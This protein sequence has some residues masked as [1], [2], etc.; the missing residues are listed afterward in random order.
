MSA[1]QYYNDSIIK[2]KIK[3][4]QLENDIK[5][6]KYPKKG[7]E[8]DRKN[9]LIDEL[10]KVK[11]ELQNLQKLQ[12]EHDE[13]MKELKKQNKLNRKNKIEEWK[14]LDIASKKKILHDAKLDRKSLQDMFN[15]NVHTERE[16][17]ELHNSNKDIIQKIK[18]N[19]K[20]TK[21]LEK[22]IKKLNK[23]IDQLY[24]KLDKNYSV[25]LKK[26]LD[27]N[28]RQNNILNKKR[29]NYQMN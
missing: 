7:E 3:I 2:L 24:I 6:V 25:Q 8:K 5:A 17:E 21:D 13:K 14:N 11:N 28:K 20:E 12:K 16:L 18:N 29:I 10:I 27:K 22:Q 26:E 23:V 4:Q 19:K 1:N 15:Y 9:K